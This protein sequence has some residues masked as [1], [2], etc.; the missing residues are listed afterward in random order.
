MHLAFGFHRVLLLFSYKNNI[1]S[2]FTVVLCSGH[3]SIKNLLIM[4]DSL[5]NNFS[6]ILVSE[7]R[8]SWVFIGNRQF[9]LFIVIRECFS[10]PTCSSSC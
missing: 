3:V 5:Q 1:F 8:F 2:F 6:K 4:D 7:H 9:M 10:L